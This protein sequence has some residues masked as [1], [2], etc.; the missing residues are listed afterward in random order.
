MKKSAMVLLLGLALAGAAAAKDPSPTI[1]ARKDDA[2][3]ASAAPTG[4]NAAK[5]A[6]NSTKGKVNPNAGKEGNVDPYKVPLL[7]DARPLN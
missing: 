4:P 1:T 5:L 7:R 6:G 2:P 3:V